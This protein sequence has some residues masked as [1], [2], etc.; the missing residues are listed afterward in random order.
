MSSKLSLGM[1]NKS[2]KI[3]VDLNQEFNTSQRVL[4]TTATGTLSRWA[5]DKLHFYCP[6]VIGQIS[7]ASNSCI[8]QLGPGFFQFL[9]GSLVSLQCLLA[10]LSLSAVNTP[11]TIHMIHRPMR[12]RQEQKKCVHITHC[13]QLILFHFKYVWAWCHVTHECQSLWFICSLIHYMH[14]A[15]ANKHVIHVWSV[16]WVTISITITNYTS[17]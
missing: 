10:Y 1:R 3:P 11:H 2:T 14:P 16:G 4:P 5:E 6:D 12:E 17:A 7:I 13:V 9:L 15:Q 8:L